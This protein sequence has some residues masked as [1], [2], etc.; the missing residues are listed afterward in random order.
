M[1][2]P[3]GRPLPVETFG[4]PQSSLA[5]VVTAVLA[6]AVLV[7]AVLV[8]AVVW[9]TQ[10]TNAA[11]PVADD[12]TVQA[13]CLDY[14]KYVIDEYRAGLSVEQIT[15]TLTQA[16]RISAGVPGPRYDVLTACGNASAVLH[17]AGLK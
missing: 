11:R 7:V 6:L 10:D 16:G 3:V 17:A 5:Q 2:V 9:D 1:G 13:L 4:R 8:L 14:A 12:A 15:A